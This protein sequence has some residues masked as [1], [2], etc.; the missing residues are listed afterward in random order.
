MDDPQVRVIGIERLVF[1]SASLL[2]PDHGNNVYDH[3]G[4]KLGTAN[5]VKMIRAAYLIFFR[6]ISS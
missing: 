6:V 3:T 1:D 5:G 4:N 2:L